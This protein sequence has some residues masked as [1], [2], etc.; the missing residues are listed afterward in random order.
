MAGFSRLPNRHQ[1]PLVVVKRCSGFGLERITSGTAE[2]KVVAK[3]S[4]DELHGQV[5]VVLTFVVENE[6]VG[7]GGPEVELNEEGVKS[8]DLGQG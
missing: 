1:M 3:L 2:A 8:V 4:V 7:L 6:A 5:V